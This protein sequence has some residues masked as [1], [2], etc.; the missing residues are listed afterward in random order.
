MAIYQYSS[1][2]I[3]GILGDHRDERILKIFMLVIPHFK[4][5]KSIGCPGFSPCLMIAGFLRPPGGSECQF[6]HFVL[7]SIGRLK[8]MDDRRLKN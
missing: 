5:L 8:A 7:T 6:S 3:H 1:M 4:L 2:R